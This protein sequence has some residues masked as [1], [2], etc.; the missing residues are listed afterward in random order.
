MGINFAFTFFG[1]VPWQFMAILLLVYSVL[2]FADLFKRHL[3]SNTVIYWATMLLAPLAAVTAV[4][5]PAAELLI[6]FS[7]EEMR[8]GKII[9]LFFGGAALLL[10]T[11][12][13]YIRGHIVPLNKNSEK[14]GDNKKYFAAKRLIKVGYAGTL[15]YI[16]PFI[17]MSY[18]IIS[19]IFAGAS[20][21]ANI[22][23]EDGLGTA[24]LWL[25]ALLLG[26][27]IPIVNIIFI[28]VLFF[29]GIEFFVWG[30]TAAAVLLTNVLIANG[31]IRYIITTD[32]TK[33]Q[34]ALRIFLSL[35][36]TVNIFLGIR[37]CK[38]MKT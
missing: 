23:E 12:V 36:P 32:M 20:A 19:L 31:C 34:K 18:E 24:V 8:W 37:Y 10:L 16:A 15:I 3:L 25:L 17:V 38:K 9:L 27:L 4:S 11:A 30:V 22:I 26:F 33:G 29:L 7:N 21:F 14:Y 28:C 5:V 2:V 13:I 1:S 35:I 6:E